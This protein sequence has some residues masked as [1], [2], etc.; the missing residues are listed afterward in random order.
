MRFA[1]EAFEL[2]HQ[3]LSDL[4]Q[5]MVRSRHRRSSCDI[6][7][8]TRTLGSM[9]ERRTIIRRVVGADISIFTS[10]SALSEQDKEVHSHSRPTSVRVCQAEDFL[11][12]TYQRLK[13]C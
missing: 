1:R 4:N 3:A 8:V 7:A 10:S 6:Q 9:A 2:T 13:P 5:P 11:Y 12:R